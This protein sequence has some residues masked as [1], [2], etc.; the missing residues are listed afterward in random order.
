M[1]FIDRI[2]HL[3]NG[4]TLALHKKNKRMKGNIALPVILF[5]SILISAIEPA[6]CQ[7]KNYKCVK[8]YTNDLNGS[9]QVDSLNYSVSIDVNNKIIEIIEPNPVHF[10]ILQIKGEHLGNNSTKKVTVY[11]VKQG[12]GKR[13]EIT[14]IT[15]YPNE[16][17]G[18]P[19][20]Q[21][22]RPHLTIGHKQAKK[23]P[24]RLWFLASI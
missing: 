14:L 19:I 4:K 21:C 23:Y 22:S 11:S 9:Q 13:L 17:I 20:L 5:I 15:D 18:T 7:L 12:N 10:K 6:Y 16:N 3:F 2:N 24:Y 1:D 8:K